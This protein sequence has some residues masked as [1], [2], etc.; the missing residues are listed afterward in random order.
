MKAVD[1]DDNSVTDHMY[2]NE[3]W[4]VVEIRR[5]V[6]AAPDANTAPYKQFVYDIRYIDAPV[7]R[8]WDK[9]SDGTMEPT[10]GEMQYF[11]N[12][13]NFN[14]TALIDANSGG[15]VERYLYDPYGKPTVLN[16][17][18]GAEKDPNV[19][20][21]SPDA[22]NKSDWDNEILFCGYWYDP[23]TGLFHVRERYYDPLTGTW[24]TR[25]RI[26]Y[27]D[28]MTLYGY[29]ENNPIEATDPDGLVTL[30]SP[31]YGWQ[32]VAENRFKAITDGA[33][34]HVLSQMV[35]EKDDSWQCLWPVPP[36]Q[37][38]AKSR[39]LY[40]Q[41]KAACN[42]V[43]DVSNLTAKTGPS[44]E[45]IFVAK[46][47]VA[48][49]NGVPKIVSYGRNLAIWYSGFTE[50]FE[51]GSDIGR[52]LG[53]LS[54]WGRTPIDSFTLFSHSANGLS[55]SNGRDK[56]FGV[57][58]LI[59]PGGDAFDLAKDHKGPRLCWF[60]PG[61]TV[62]FV[63]CRTSWIA[64]LYWA[65]NLIRSG[66]SPLFNSDSGKVYGTNNF[67]QVVSPGGGRFL[68]YPDLAK[69][70]ESKNPLD[71][72]VTTPFVPY[73]QLLTQSSLVWYYGER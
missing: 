54:Q 30:R 38:E 25:D 15:V 64:Y 16:G 53:E 4:Q 58:D 46:D 19:T 49:I 35:V 28:G 62:R 40:K 65:K 66:R 21:W 73:G 43:Y 10:A 41:A 24:K 61:A 60:R 26:L 50:E 3:S 31:F 8:W 5:G 47:T 42:D 20:E 17:A 67:L 11:T 14:T 39:K 7:C 27:P 56:Y 33:D 59:N 63:G 22:D 34:I 9:D 29:V 45:G 55:L 71:P 18:A 57:N 2:H 23:E 1:V 13:G 48:N 51:K 70:K 12:D 32:Q 69:I 68:T 72:S 36:F 6:N 44:L 37:D 52:K